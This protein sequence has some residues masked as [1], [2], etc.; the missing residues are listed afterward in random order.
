MQAKQNVINNGT[1]SCQPTNEAS[2]F[3]S[4]DSISTNTY[5]LVIW[6]TFQGGL[7]RFPEVSLRPVF[8][9]PT[10]PSDAKGVKAV[11]TLCSWVDVREWH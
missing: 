8:I 3:Q 4:T 5:R 6:R 10:V 7:S 9:S 1:W 2:P 11:H